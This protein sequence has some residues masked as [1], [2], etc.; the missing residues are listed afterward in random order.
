MGTSG[1][2]QNKLGHMDISQSSKPQKDQ[3]GVQVNEL[4]LPSH[5]HVWT[6][7]HETWKGARFRASSKNT[8]QQEQ[9]PLP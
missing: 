2:L 7:E 3:C 6:H 5:A 4:L 1:N 9:L 8:Q